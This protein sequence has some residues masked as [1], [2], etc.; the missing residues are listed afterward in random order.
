MSSQFIPCNANITLSHLAS[1]AGFL[2]VFLLRPQVMHGRSLASRRVRPLFLYFPL[3]ISKPTRFLHRQ[4]FFLSDFRF[5]FLLMRR[6][7]SLAS[8]R[9]RSSRRRCPSSR[10]PPKPSFSTTCVMNKHD[11]KKRTGTE[12]GRE[13]GDGGVA[14]YPVV[15]G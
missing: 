2:G 12:G 11:E 5:F 4:L 8:R 13:G 15:K 14:F 3:S 7:W 1:T 6:L 10:P 9:A